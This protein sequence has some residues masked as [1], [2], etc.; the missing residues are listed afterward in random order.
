[1]DN[2]F[3]SQEWSADTMVDPG[4]IRDLLDSFELAGR[5]I[6]DLRFVGMDY[7][8][9]RDFIE[10]IA[11]HQ[12]KQYEEEE[13]HRR[14]DYDNIDPGTVYKRYA[15]IDEPLLIRFE[16]GNRFEIDTPQEP[17]FR[18]SMN[19]IP[20][21]IGE[22][23]NLRNIDANVLFSSCIGKTIKE[24]V[25]ETYRTDKDPMFGMEFDDGTG[26]RELASWIVLKFHD[27]T[28]LKIGP[29]FDF[30][31]V[32][33]CNRDGQLEEFTFGEFKPGIFNQEDKLV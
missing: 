20:W 24:A 21:F 2:I 11:Y 18:F 7:A 12:L 32:L 29:H 31:D 15:E 4:E 26:E 10:D 27:G 1:M 6:K 9:S 5:K 8:H 13:R 33:L 30:C 23:T 22:G 19:C 16:D 28:C 17:E 3:S 14:A 25:V